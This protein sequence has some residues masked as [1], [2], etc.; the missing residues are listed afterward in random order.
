MHIVSRW[1]LIVLT[2]VFHPSLAA[3]QAASQTFFIDA[4]GAETGIVLESGRAT[5]RVVDAAANASPTGVEITSATIAVNLTGDFES[6]GLV[7][8]GPD[9]GVFE[10][11][12]DLVL[13]P[14][15]ILGNGLLE[16]TEVP[17]PFEPDTLTAVHVDAT[18]QS[19]AVATTV[20]SRLWL[21]DA[22]GA[23][24]VSYPEGAAIYVRIEDQ[25][26]NQPGAWDQ[27]SFSVQAAISGDDDG[28][29]LLETSKSS[30]IFEGWMPIA[31]AAS[32][33][34]NDGVLQ[35]D[36]G[37]TITVSHMDL[38][39]NSS[40][41]AQAQITATELRFLGAGGLPAVE[42][43]ENGSARVWL[44]SFGDNLDPA[45][46]ETVVADLESLQAGDGENLALTETGADTGVFEGSVALASA[47]AAS[48][49]GVLETAWGGPP[50]FAG[51][52]LTASYS[53]GSAS[54]TVVGSRVVFVDAY[55]RETATYALSEQVI[56]RITDP[57]RDDPQVLDSQSVTLTVAATGDAETIQ[58]LET[59]ADSGVFEGGVA[60]GAGQSPQ[61]GVLWAD[62]GD[63]VAV[64]HTNPAATSTRCA[65]ATITGSATLFIDA[66]GLPANV[67]MESHRAILRVIDSAENA[68]PGAADVTSAT[69]AVELT[70]D[71]E[72]LSL[73]ETGADTGV[74]EGTIDLDR[75]AVAITGNG[76]LET[77]QI[78]GP[79]REL[80]T[81]TAVHVDSW[82]ESSALATTLGSRVWFIDAAGE[83]TSTLP[84]GSAVG[85]RIEDHNFN[86][87]GQVD[88]AAADLATSGGDDE[89]QYLLET[90]P[91]TGIFEGQFLVS[92]TAAVVPRDG[93]LQVTA[94]EAI[95]ATHM[96]DVTFF[97]STAQASVLAA[98]APEVLLVGRSSAA[99]WP[100]DAAVKSRLESLGYA[101]T[102]RGQ[103]EIDVADAEGKAL[104]V[105]SSTLQSTSVGAT[106]RDVEVPVLLWEAFILDDMAMTGGV[107]HSDYGS[108]LAQQEVMIADSGHP[109]A[110]G[111]TG[112]RQV[113]TADRKLVWGRPAAS[114]RVV[115]TAVT[116]SERAAIF[117]YEEGAAMVGLAAPARRVGFFL[118]DDSATVLTAD[119]WALFDA[120][121][122]WAA[123]CTGAP[124]AR[125]TVSAPPGPLPLVASFDASTSEAVG[126][127]ITSY[128]W[129]FGDSAT[130]QGVTTGHTYYVAGSYTVTLTVTDSLGHSDVATATIDAG[131]PPEVLL[132]AQQTTLGPADGAV[133]SRLESLGYVVEVVSQGQSQ[134]SQAAGKALVMV[135]S[136]VQSSQ[137]GAKF[138]DVAVPFITWEAWI[139]DDMKMTGTGKDVSYGRI[140]G[141]SHLDVVGPGHPLAAGLSGLVQVVPGTSLLR[142][143]NPSAA[144]AVVAVAEN[145]PAKALIFG[146]QAGDS[147][148]G[149]SAPA[150]RV[151]LP[152]ADDSAAVFTAEGWALF[153]AAVAW[154]VE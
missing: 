130:D 103:D 147:M 72:S 33:S 137:V 87:S 96:D 39:Y 41:T 79:I 104:V 68:S 25:N 2:L 102:L 75:S 84:E 116:D 45:V 24:A 27:A 3:G 92:A 71:F 91:S 144:A 134:A 122:C 37:D 90:G 80:D 114:A 148:V 100:G 32:V 140:L 63:L 111:L 44:A 105:I 132:V 59:A 53:D 99:P 85:V 81:L 124:I 101:V 152:F 149:L 11:G 54:A 1:V 9:T 110:A 129:D 141:Q 77:T 112:L 43:L 136:T 145:D 65:E 150:R 58:L 40:S 62:P 48:G 42:V 14:A 88:Q 133:K 50:D 46:A 64:C 126:A 31:P 56:V 60:S 98:P 36:A 121:V 70:G 8:T 57:S 146:Y 74:F 154:A 20:G 153:D 55:G 151:G 17:W 18:G 47:P 89:G 7:E 94:G 30:G 131:T 38:L 10:G 26:L 82:G 109:V 127:P 34:P 135:S 51:D 16:T 69:I 108:I 66:A 28:L 142:W 86:Q 97:L 67:V 139:Y 19:S 115:A 52:L 61:D 6:L 128:D 73:V 119:G 118:F 107:A 93:V 35:A 15:A 95:T 125:F 123:N 120:A 49:N 4:E 13:S 138:R 78:D 117:S 143:G 22:E 29:Y 83:V 5:V 23:P 106:F 113:T 12:I 76:L 21:I